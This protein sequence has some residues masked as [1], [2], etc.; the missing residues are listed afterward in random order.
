[1]ICLGIEST[2]HSFSIGI[3]DDK[4]KVYSC[5][6]DMHKG[7]PGQGIVPIEAAKHHEEV[8]NSTLEKVLKKSKLDIN[9]KDVSKKD[10]KRLGELGFF[11][12]NGDDC[13]MSFYYG[14]S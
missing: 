5:L 6:T 14:S 1:M 11:W 12:S 3:I 9:I 8:K 13:F 10:I 7:K 4:G 2:A